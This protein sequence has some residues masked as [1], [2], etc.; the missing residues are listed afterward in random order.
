MNSAFIDTNVIIKYFAGFEEARKLL[1]PV[2]RGD[3]EGYINVIVYSEVVF[4][5]LRLLT[6]KN[7]YRLR[8]DPSLVSRVAREKLTDYIEFLE[9]Y[10]HELEVTNEVKRIAF[11]VMRDYGLLPNDALI[12]A[13]C[14]YYGIKTV[15]TFDE[16]FERIPW[17]RVRRA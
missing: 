11:E 10:F 6:G 16:D 7:A 12:A 9:S 2:L 13:T 17:L 15:I 3:L 14:R 4:I 1:N 8:E 5:L